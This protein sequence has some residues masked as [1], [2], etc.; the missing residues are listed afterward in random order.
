MPS[1]VSGRRAAPAALFAVV[2]SLVLATRVFVAFDAV[3]IRVVTDSRQVSTGIVRMN[4]TDERADALRPPA[5]VIARIANDSTSAQ[6]ISVRVNGRTICRVNVPARVSRRVDC[7]VFDSWARGVDPEIV[8]E[9]TEAASWKL[10]YLELATH[11]G[12][13]TGVVHAFVLPA[14]STGY[15]RPHSAWAVVTG[16]VLISLFLLP[17]P[18]FS[19]RPVRILYS[20][21]SAIVF[22]FFV[23]VQ[24]SPVLSP[25]RLVLSMWTFSGLVSLPVAP[26]VWL[27]LTRIDARARANPRVEKLREHIVNIAAQLWRMVRLRDAWVAVA[28]GVTV[29]GIG[30]AYGSRAIGGADQYGYVSQA[31]LWLR[32]DLRTEQSFVS[33][34]PWPRAAWAFSPLGYRPYYQ[35]ER[36]IVPV[37]PPGLPMALAGV[38]RFAGHTA[39]FGVVPLTAGLLVLATYGVGRR[40][41]SSGVGL[42]GAWL[43]A[44]SPTVLFMM[45]Q[46]M[47]DVPVAAAWTWAFFLLLGP[48]TA[49]AAAAG[50][51][52]SAAVLIRP[53]LAPLV[54]IL[55]L[56]YLF[57]IRHS[58]RRGKALAQL[59]M[60]LSGALPGITA[61]AL[62][63]RHLFGSPLMSGYGSAT[64]L[65]DLSN[66][67]ANLRNYLAWLIESHTPV[68]LG[69]LVA[70]FV[71]ARRLWPG[72]RDRSVFIVIGAFVAFVWISYCAWH[73]FDDRWWFTR[74]LLA[75]WP[76]IMIGAGAIFAA[77]YHA[78]P[79]RIRPVVVVFVIAVGVVQIRFAAEHTAFVIGAGDRRYVGGSRLVG[80]MTEPNSVIVSHTF[81]GAIRY[82]GGRMTLNY[83][84]LPK[85]MLDEAVDSLRSHGVRTYAALEDWEV[86]PFRQR[87]AGARCLTS[88]DRKPIAIYQE[89]GRLL[90]F[91]LSELRPRSEPVVQTDIELGW[92][93]AQPVS[94]PELVITR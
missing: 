25:Y 90:L 29:S 20:V 37:Y 78:T 64:E 70:I 76:L 53:N 91:D 36:F 68:A 92:R 72:L 23:L 3:R 35:D 26:R 32:H 67:P 21:V 38:K 42:I 63:N 56:H 81:V 61:V 86:T 14:A 93:A 30:L 52:S 69:G 19:I 55:S 71:P 60:F 48:N 88:L 18:I 22:L 75:T 49:N 31:E 40:L 6:Q 5:A 46:T 79:T 2:S 27:V 9:S 45:M 80:R 74:L 44:N 10:E 47:T 7:V 54:A 17:P 4:V 85:E 57:K 11:H 1:H 89:P 51:I 15:S 24:L 34:L 94:P 33:E 73:I 8:L 65:Y 62:I 77:A 12:R 66:V 16:L 41:R 58:S 84:N 82:Y 43:I 13:T 50:L 87:F 39:M 28:M 59:A 83:E